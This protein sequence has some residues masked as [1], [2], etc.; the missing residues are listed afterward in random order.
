MNDAPPLDLAQRLQHAWLSRGPLTRA[1]LPFA[2]LFG[3]VTALR[4]TLYRWGWLQAR[5]L[6]VPVIVVGNLIAGGAGKTPTVMASVQLLR[7]RGYAPGIVSR[8]YGRR[9]DACLEVQADMPA[10]SCGD[11]PL[12]MHLRTGVPVVVARDRVAAA[13]LLLLRHPEVDVLV[14][15]DGLQHLRLAR[16]AQVLVFDER[17]AGNG[18]LLP[19]GP[20]RE[21]LPPTVPV[22]SIVLYNAPAPS[23][24]L[25][26]ELARRSLA[27]VVSLA[28]WWQGQTASISALAALR[29][30]PL[31]AAAGVARPQRFFAMLRDAGL[32]T[33]PLA[34]PDHHDYRTLP[35]APETADV[36]LT[37]KDAIKIDPRRV[38]S[39]RV[40]VA[41]LDFSPAATFDAALIALLPPPGIAHGNAPS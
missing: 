6:P 32:T 17:G 36:V 29:G 25:P 30:R 1:L 38:G 28:A 33:T 40:W 31:I 16:S 11:E 41:A 22:R 10:S 2:A 23:T 13:R 37:E 21:R 19:A 8:G 12:L 24:A 18:W 9:D 4:R 26:G 39:T 34:L 7:R 3:A 14:S 15:D 20:L 35:W 27:G 5:T